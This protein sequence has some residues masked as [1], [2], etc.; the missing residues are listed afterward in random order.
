VLTQVVGNKVLALQGAGSGTATV[1][2]TFPGTASSAALTT[3]VEVEV[4]VVQRTSV[5]THPYP[6]YTGSTSVAENTLSRV[7][8]TSVFQYAEARLTVSLGFMVLVFQ[9]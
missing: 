3:F 5:S 9:G 2:V 8:C 6:P 7:Q 4:L 1:S